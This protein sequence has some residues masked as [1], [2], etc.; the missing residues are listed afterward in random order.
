[1]ITFRPTFLWYNVRDKKINFFAIYNF[2]FMVEGKG[3]ISMSIKMV[4]YIL[5]NICLWAII[6]VINLLFGAKD[7]REY[8]NEYANYNMLAHIFM[9]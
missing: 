3:N 6:F 2:I 5:Q 8:L 4:I 7:K 1:M 9:G